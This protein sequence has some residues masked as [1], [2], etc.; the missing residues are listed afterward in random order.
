MQQIELHSVQLSRDF[1]CPGP[2]VYWQWTLIGSRW[3]HKV[4]VSSTSF[5]KVLKEGEL[6]CACS[7][8]CWRKKI[9]SEFGV[10]QLQDHLCT[11]LRR[12]EVFWN[13]LVNHFGIT[14]IFNSGNILLWNIQEVKKRGPR[15]QTCIYYEFLSIFYLQNSWSGLYQKEHHT[16]KWRPKIICKSLYIAVR[17]EA[18]M[19]CWSLRETP[20]LIF[21]DKS[22]L[23][24]LVSLYFTLDWVFEH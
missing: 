20:L 21:T 12:Y 16:L 1:L 2:R 3:I 14:V 18:D 17:K 5:T 23:D 11:E 15:F 19:L 9:I 6:C 22:M 10:D 24:S 13:T 4:K 8:L 7:L